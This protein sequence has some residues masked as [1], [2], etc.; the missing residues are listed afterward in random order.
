MHLSLWII[1][2]AALPSIAAAQTTIRVTTRLVDISVI[3]RDA[4]GPVADLSR[5]DFAVFDNG[6]ERPV[7]F[8]SMNSTKLPGKPVASPPN[9]F[10]NRAESREDAPVRLTVFVLDALNSDF[11]TQSRSRQQLLRYLP[12]ITPRDRVAIWVLTEHLRRIQEFTNDVQQL[13]KSVE[14]FTPSLWLIPE[15]AAGAAARSPASQGEVMANAAADIAGGMQQYYR[16]QL[17]NDLMQELGT[18]LSRIPGRKNVIWLSSAFP[19]NMSIGPG[20]PETEYVSGRLTGTGRALAKADAALYPVD[21]RGL[22]APAGGQ[23]AM[24]VSMSERH[25]HD[26]LEL[27]AATSGGRAIY[28]TNDIA[29]ALGEAM[30]DTQITYTVGFYPET[31]GDGKDY[32][33]L[34][35]DVKRPGV[36]LRYRPG[37]VATGPPAQST[38]PD[39]REEISNALASPLDALGI[40]FTVRVEP[41]NPQRPGWVPIVILIPTSDITLYKGKG[42]TEGIA[43]LVVSQRAAD[44]RDLMTVSDELRLEPQASGSSS[45]PAGLLVRRQVQLAPRAARIRVLLFD[46][47]SGRV[48]SLEFSAPAR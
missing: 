21:A 28:D 23:S 17:T 38:E 32:H 3:A 14:H 22:V 27:L 6:V 35:I 16:M 43:D 20:G 33:N 18:S 29:A 13:T 40:S 30:D 8:F 47:S 48:G 7:A 15:G 1:V 26:T 41:R 44:G 11:E 37:Y 46:R 31:A 12:K 45:P 4:K 19:L 36:T 9:T 25:R 42:S 5:N 24:A 39:G 34:R 2:L 10:T